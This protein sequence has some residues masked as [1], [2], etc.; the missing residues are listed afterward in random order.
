[1]EGLLFDVLRIR[2]P[3]TKNQK[4]PS[5]QFLLQRAHARGWIEHDALQ[6]GD[7]AR[8]YRNLVHPREQLMLKFFPDDDTLL[9]CWQP[10]LAMINDL[11]KLLPGLTPPETDP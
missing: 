3:E 4:E 11:S 8:E 2:D 6:F 10:A 7:L 9:L 1:M 5:L